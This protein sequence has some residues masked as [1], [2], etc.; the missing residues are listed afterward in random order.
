MY[1][2]IHLIQH[3][4]W[5]SHWAEI[6][7]SWSLMVMAWIWHKLLFLCYELFYLTRMWVSLLWVQPRSIRY[8]KGCFIKIDDGVLHNLGWVLTAMHIM[9]VFSFPEELYN[10]RLSHTSLSVCQWWIASI[11][12]EIG[13]F[14]EFRDS[15][16]LKVIKYGMRDSIP[17]DFTHYYHRN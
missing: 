9:L 4:A 2:D 6:Q 10:I 16:T 14:V 17:V 3:Y 7:W 1:F 12:F 15:M 13:L 5:T 8:I 11:V